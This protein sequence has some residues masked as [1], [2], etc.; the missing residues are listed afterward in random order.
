MPTVTLLAK[1]Y[2]ATNRR[3]I[4]GILRS[5]LE[6]LKVRIRIVNATERGWIQLCVEG[7]DE[8]VALRFLQKEIGI[9]PENLQN[10]EAG[11]IFTGRLVSLEK[12]T[13]KLFVD[14]GVFSPNVVD[15]GIPLSHLQALLMDGRKEKL[16]SIVRLFN[17]CENLPMIIEISGL[18]ENSQRLKATIA[19]EQ[20]SR[21]DFWM[22]S[23]LDRLVI[24]GVSL[25]QVRHAVKALGLSRDIV[26]TEQLGLLEYAAECK[27][28]TDA[29]GLIS[30][31]GK[32]LP[33]AKFSLF[34]PRKI[35]QVYARAR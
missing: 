1:G 3:I 2:G 8:S 29:A 12:S 4:E 6:G 26:K 28:G 18:D 21:Y 19:E 35:Q 15:A 20:L 22:R 27:L 7:E 5:K 10:V 24:L 14:V 34:C 17:F 25:T 32:A 16:N 13:E 30:R 9:C 31:I 23:L 11:S 33:S